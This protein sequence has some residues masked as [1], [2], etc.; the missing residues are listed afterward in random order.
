MIR[1]EAVDSKQKLK[2]FIDFPHELYKD[3]K[4][5]VPELFIAQRD[6]LT[7]GKHPFHDHSS[8]QAFIA[9]KGDTVVGRIA[10]IDNKNHNTFN[11]TNDGFFGFFD[12]VNDEEVSKALLD[13]VHEWLKKKGFNTMIGPV[14]FSTNETCGLLVEGFDTPPFV[15]MTYNKP[16]YESHLHAFGLEKKCDLLA[17]LWEGEQ[18][19][20]KP[21]KM[22]D[23]LAKRLQQKGIVIRPVNLKNFKAEVKQIKEVYNSAW[24]KNLGFVP[25]TDAEFDYMAKDLKMLLDTDFCLVAE[26]EGKIVGFALALPNV[27][28]ILIRI[29]K[30]RLFP[31]GIIKLLTS[32]KKIRSVRIIA[33]GV[34]EKYRKMGIEAC[35]YASFLIAYKRKKFNRAEAS[36]VLEDNFLMNNAIKEMNAV[37]YK[38][39][40]IYE[41]KI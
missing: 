18:D 29:K 5:Y 37:P 4:N 23:T 3:D 14:N 10:A 7:P 28:E 2:T 12:V 16:Y 30:G 27:N 33:L 11:K 19:D 35:F 38:K 6:L 24:D 20:Y 21:V 8:I 36:W 26:Q 9:Y 17:H 13:T 41:K 39:Y 32:L 25:M 1:I 34:I 15:M 31:F 22:M 40:R